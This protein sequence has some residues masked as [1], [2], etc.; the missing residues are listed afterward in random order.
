MTSNATN[1][2][3]VTVGSVISG[4]ASGAASGAAIG[5]VP[6]AI[7]GGAL[8]LG[9]SLAGRKSDVDEQ[10]GEIDYG[11]GIGSW[12]GHSKSYLRNKSGRIKNG[13]LSRENSTNI[14]AD[15]YD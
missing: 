6:G 1:G 5:G 3:D 10:T 12:F 15:Y 2:Q 4:T 8:G 7:V 11:S 13:I 14:A 9:T